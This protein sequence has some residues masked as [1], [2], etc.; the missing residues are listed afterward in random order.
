MKNYL[1]V[2]TKEGQKQNVPI[3]FN[4]SEIKVKVAKWLGIE[5][6]EIK[7]I[8]FC[9]DGKI[10]PF[11][12]FKNKDYFNQSKN[13]IKEKIQF[14]SAGG[15]LDNFDKLFNLTKED[16]GMYNSVNCFSGIISSAIKNKEEIEAYKNKDELSA[17]PYRFFTKTI[18]KK[19]NK[20]KERFICTVKP[21]ERNAKSSLSAKTNEFYSIVK[22]M[23]TGLVTLEDEMLG[24]GKGVKDSIKYL[25]NGDKIIKLDFKDFFNNVSIKKVREG[26]EKN[27]IIKDE[28][29]LNILSLICCPKYK[30]KRRTWQGLPTSTLAAYIALLPTF[31]QVKQHTIENYGV[32]PTIYIDDFAMKINVDMKTAIKIKKEIST[33][34]IKGKF[35]LNLEK[36]KVLFGNKTFFLG[37]NMKTQGLG[38]KT[39][40]RNLRAYI[41]NAY[42]KTGNYNGKLTIQK[43]LGKI[44][45]LKHISE[46]QFEKLVKHEKYGKYLK[47]I[48]TKNDCSEAAKLLELVG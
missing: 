13:Q 19:N 14:F 44:T 24:C 11:N 12:V 36:S 21:K 33:M 27:S 17:L 46:E 43:L 47:D 4:V 30:E 42:F 35:I 6:T 1:V 5:L 18:M 40:I 8:S 25:E 10:I 37:V 38:R 16:L 32:T 45:Y 20:K 22:H 23:L 9:I 34:F 39:Y 48:A 29:V 26:L 31:K 15:K 2:E 3:F 28:K 41:N 7:K